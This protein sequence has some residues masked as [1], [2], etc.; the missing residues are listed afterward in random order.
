VQADGKRGLDAKLD[1]EEGPKQDFADRERRPNDQRKSHGGG[2]KRR[3]DGDGRQ[4]QCEEG[5]HGEEPPEY[6]AT[7]ME[8]DIDLEERQEARMDDLSGVS[9]DKLASSKAHSQPDSGNE[10]NLEEEL[11]LS[12]RK[13]TERER[14][15]KK[16]NSNLHNGFEYCIR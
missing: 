4:D 14:E 6:V 10:E 11:A 15:A 9:V 13:K 2:V 8:S 7:Q 16:F 12:S 1:E 3:E 5:M